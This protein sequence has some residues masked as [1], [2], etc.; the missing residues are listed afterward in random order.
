MENGHTNPFKLEKISIEASKYCR[1]FIPKA[2][3]EARK[4]EQP[5]QQQEQ[6][7]SRGRGI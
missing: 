7:Q 4:A 6:A 2:L 5:Q 1:E 3:A